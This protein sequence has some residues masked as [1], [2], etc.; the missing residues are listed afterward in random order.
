MTS[1]VVPIPI[2]WN[3]QE[4][5]VLCHYASK[6]EK[7]GLVLKLDDEDNEA[8]EG[9][10]TDYVEHVPACFLQRE[11]SEAVFHRPSPLSHLVQALVQELAQTLQETRGGCVSILPNTIANV[12]KSQACRGKQINI[13]YL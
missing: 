9:Q 8:N 12:L 7:L 6:L 1:P 10:C 5:R 3:S 2:Q 11:A 13:Y 4:K